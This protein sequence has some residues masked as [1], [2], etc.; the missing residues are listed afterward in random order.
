MRS[1]QTLVMQKFKLQIL[2]KKK[3]DMYFKN[4]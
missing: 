4:I 1:L 3:I 2:I